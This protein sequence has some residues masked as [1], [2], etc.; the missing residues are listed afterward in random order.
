VIMQESLDLMNKD[1]RLTDLVSL[2]AKYRSCSVARGSVTSTSIA[3]TSGSTS[4][5]NVKLTRKRAFWSVS[6]VTTSQ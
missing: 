2:P 6:L 5:S 1:I 4:E 3:G